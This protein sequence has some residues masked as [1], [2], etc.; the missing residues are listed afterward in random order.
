MDA[1]QL[2]EALA[3]SCL[4][5][6]VLVL[7]F[8]LQKLDAPWEATL[9]Q[10]GLKRRR[11]MEKSPLWSLCAPPIHWL[12]SRVRGVVPQV[13]RNR[14]NALLSQA[15][16]PLGLEP[17]ELIV[18]SLFTSCAGGAAGAVYSQLMSRSPGLYV[19][20]CCMLGAM[21]P[22]L[23]I[24]AQRQDRVVAIQ[25]GIPHV[26]DLLC[27]SLSAGLDFT[28]SVRQI[29]G[30]TG[31]KASALADELSL[32]LTELNLG[33]T[34][35]QALE[36]FARRNPMNAVQELTG[37][38]IQ[39]EEEGSPLATSLKIQARVSRQRR[40]VNAEVLAGKASIKIILPVGLAMISVLLLI[41]G[42]LLLRVLQDMNRG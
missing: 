24:D 28:N 1:S 7:V 9:G 12:A 21:L 34:R 23:R 30:K 2:L 41:S 40:S 42:P 38:I 39:S 18:L 22:V 19:A 16:D 11:A 33:K 20:F 6:A 4:F 37:A 25:R 26:V 8:A 17:E 3:L 13:Y 10:R 35:R 27:L 15:G 29:I 14:L 5:L 31:P 32:L 36:L